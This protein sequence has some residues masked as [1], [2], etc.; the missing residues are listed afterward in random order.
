MKVLLDTDLL[1]DVALRRTEF[2]ANSAAVLRW[3]ESNPGRAAVAWHSLANLSY[4]LQPDARPFIREL[5]EF[6]VVPMTGTEA[7][8]QAIAFPM[9]DFEDA[10]QAASALAFGAHCIVTRNTSDYRRSP[11]PAISPGE[12]I[13]DV[14]P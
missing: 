3:A 5:L 4:L 14:I 8:R 1:L 2:L 11:V 13:K 10:L 9:S 6:V 7:A 12:F